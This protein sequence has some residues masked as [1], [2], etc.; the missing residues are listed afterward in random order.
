VVLTP[1]GILV[2]GGGGQLANA[3]MAAAGSRPLVRVG[4]PEF[5]FDRPE[6]IPALLRAAAPSL[7]LNA[8]AYTAVDKAETDRDAAWRANCDGPRLL[9]EYC[10]GAGIPLIHVSTDYVFDG[11]KGAPYVET[12]APNPTGVYGASKR[13]GEAAVL[14]TGAHAII[15]RTSWV[16]AAT[17]RNFV[18]TMLNAAAK[19][20]HL[21][22]VADQ[23]GC[24]TAAQDLAAAM[25]RIADR[26]AAAGWNDRYGGIFH[27][28]GS[29]ATTWHGFATAIFAEAAR[30][31]MVP[32]TVAPI[33]TADWP[34]P[35]RRPADSRLDC[36]KLSRVFAIVL[37]D[38]RNALSRTI[39]EVFEA[40]KIAATNSKP[41]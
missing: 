8:A 26:I 3:L 35:A 36:G 33:A 16:Y 14:A 17:G 1:G 9:A 6:A 18:L 40:R 10:V 15:L 32:P 21:R 19:T 4:R 12:D 38:W 37:P 39:T 31:G 20:G 30:H 29:G 7:I 41:L 27:A 2:T 11:D 24:P 34:T 13:A 28:A 5:D 23:Q 25:L 22:V